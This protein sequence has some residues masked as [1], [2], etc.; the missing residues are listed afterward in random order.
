[1][2]KDEEEDDV[3][4]DKDAAKGFY[5]KYEP[6]EILGRGISSTVRRCIEKETG[7]EFAAKIIDLGA[8]TEAGDTN[9]YHM[10]EATRQEISILR[11]VMGHPYIIDLQDVFESD[12]FVFLVFELC[13]KGEL[14][15]Y[16]TSVVTLSEKKTR[17]I[18]RQIFE[19][20]EY[21]HA[22]NI[23]HRDLKPENIL[24]DENHNVKITD[25]GFARQLKGDE[26]LA[27]LCG[28]PGYLAPETLKCNMFEGSPGYS[29]EVDIWAC[30]VIMFTLL[31]GCPP[32]WHR[33]QM[34][35]LRN[36]MEG[37][38][39]FTSPE[40]AD[41]SE[42]PKDLIRKC[43]VVDPA[44]RIT[45]KEVLK[46]PFFNQMV[47]CSEPST[48]GRTTYQLKSQNIRN[49]PSNG[50]QL[51][52]NPNILKTQTNYSYNKQ[53]SSYASNNTSNNNN[54]KSMTNLYLNKQASTQSNN[55]NNTYTPNTTTSPSTTFP[56]TYNNN[57]NQ[58]NYQSNGNAFDNTTAGPTTFLSTNQNN[59]SIGNATPT[60]FIT[61]EQQQQQQQQQQLLYQQHQQFIQ[62]QQQTYEQQLRKQSR[63]NARKKFQFAIL[64]IRAMIR[65]RR[66][67]YTAEPLRVEEAIRDP[68][69]VKVLRKVIDGCAF[70]V[71]GHWVK[72]GEG[73]NRA[74]LFENTPRTE[75]H[76]LY[77]NNL[78][79]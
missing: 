73:Q 40:W 36:I 56:Q 62:K 75:L 24:L 28:T 34:V 19:G 31:V 30:G 53:P 57:Y 71:Y 68:Y 38:Y 50:A 5:A 49:T 8:A 48:D 20:V 72:K 4:P 76:A 13:P 46:H 41:I 14:F 21:I 12:A 70:R 43:L 7:K 51:Y 26:K 1:M 2:A 77:I 3:L 27:D 9:P 74:A 55:T 52:Y 15:D 64:V 47:L 23:V 37:K 25:F 11:Q 45:V 65:I 67:R 10:L 60:P 39:S 61:Q 58:R 16:L 29:K 35:M 54:R 22:K 6:K 18:M 44:K 69:R 32:F 33:K 78:S 59:N 79:R 17:T 66:L 42:D 63:F